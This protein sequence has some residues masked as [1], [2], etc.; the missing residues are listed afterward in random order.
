MDLG[1]FFFKMRSY[2]LYLLTPLTPQASANAH[3]LQEGPWHALPPGTDEVSWPTQPLVSIS[4]IFP[5]TLYYSY[6]LLHLSD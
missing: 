3:L 6:S 1:G 2:L 5:F 4:S